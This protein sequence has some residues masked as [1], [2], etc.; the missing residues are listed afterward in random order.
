MTLA[1]FMGEM[2]PGK[3]QWTIAK[4]PSNTESEFENP[5]DEVSCEN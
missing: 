1:N 4:E 3:P 2:D 5:K